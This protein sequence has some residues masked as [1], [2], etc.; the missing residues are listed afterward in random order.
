MALDQPQKFSNFLV[1]MPLV[2]HLHRVTDSSPLPPVW[3]PIWNLAVY[4]FSYVSEVI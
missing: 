2:I 4:S 1:G 3:N